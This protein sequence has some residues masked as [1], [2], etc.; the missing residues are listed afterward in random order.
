MLRLEAKNPS[1]FLRKQKLSNLQSKSTKPQ[2]PRWKI[3]NQYFSYISFETNGLK[4]LNNTNFIDKRWRKLMNLIEKFMKLKK[5]FKMNDRNI[6]S[7]DLCHYFVRLKRLRL[8]L[9]LYECYVFWLC[10]YRKPTNHKI[11][12]LTKKHNAL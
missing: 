10:K 5:K 9:F 12:T 7:S 11:N 8:C 4:S 6:E 2:K 3:W 1:S